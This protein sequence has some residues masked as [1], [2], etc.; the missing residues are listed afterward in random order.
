MLENFGSWWKDKTS[1]EKKQTP[2]TQPHFK[3]SQLKVSTN[4]KDVEKVLE[5]FE[6]FNQSPM[7]ANVWWKCQTALV[8]GFTN[9]V[10][11]AHKN[12]PSHTPIELEVKVFAKYLEIRIWDYGQ[13]FDFS[14]KLQEILDNPPMDP[15][16]KEGGRGLIFMKKLTDHL[17]YS[18]GADERNCLL[19]RKNFDCE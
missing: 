7:E 2:E 3:Q 10:R 15:L 9:A 13:P 5:W 18:R 16:Q 17:E 6:Q 8:E 11:H 1:P 14:A 19:M 12:L 4:I